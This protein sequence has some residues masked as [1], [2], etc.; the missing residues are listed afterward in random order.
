[1]PQAR[2]TPVP[3]TDAKLQQLELKANEIRQDVLK[4]LTEAGSGHSAGPL[5]MADIFTALYFHVLN[6]N[7]RKPLW[8]E[9]DRLFLSN[10]HIVPIRYAT[11]A[12]A[13][14]FPKQELKT[15]RKF[16][17]RLQ[18]HPEVRL[19]PELENTSGPLGDGSPQAVG[20]AYVGMLEKATWHVYCVMSDGELAAGITWEAAL[21]ASKH[22]LHNL[23][24]IIDRN[25]I[26]IDGYTEDIMPLEPL[27]DKFA[28]F[29]FNVLEIDGHN[30]QEFVDACD[31]SKAT[32]EAPTVIIAHTIPGKNVSYM[33]FE[34]SWHGKPPQAGAELNQALK[35]LRTL[36][37]KIQ[38]EME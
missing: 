17:S 16:G 33:E 8:P 28:A 22:K 23:T 20:M 14:Y 13:G 6:H 12:H 29:G 25:N 11:L 21:F 4:M 24:W 32:W 9:R 38:S 15:L 30:I 19:L 26:Q 18:G 31:R 34:P 2:Q 7:P 3:L 35:E 37:G 10:G 36:H 5:G 1:M 27:H